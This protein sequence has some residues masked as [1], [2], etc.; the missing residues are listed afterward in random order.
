M[1]T[2]G[3]LLL[4]ALLTACDGA[5]AP[6][7]DAETQSSTDAGSDGQA[8]APSPCGIPPTDVIAYQDCGGPTKGDLYC[9]AG[10][11]ELT[12]DG[13]LGKLVD[14]GC[15]VPIGTSKPLT[16]LCVSSCSECQ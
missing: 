3:F 15:T 10:C 6:A 16:A 1:K 2:V 5:Q 4:A 9:V 8:S 14:P 11:G 7:D 12:D 13:S